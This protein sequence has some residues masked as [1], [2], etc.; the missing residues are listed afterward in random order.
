MQERC[1]RA[2]LSRSFALALSALLAL[3]TGARP[4]AAGDAATA[5]PL[6]RELSVFEA[7]ADPDAPESPSPKPTGEL[8]LA[9]ALAAALQGSP[10]LATSAYE[11]RRRE[12]LALQA[13]L[14]PNPVFSLQAEDFAGDSQDKSLGYQQTTLSLAQLVELGG[15]RMARRRLADRDRDLATWDFEAQRVAVLADTTKSFLVVL[16]LQERRTLFQD[17][18]RVAGEMLRSVASTVRAG[19][20]SPVEEDRAHVNLDRVRLEVAQIENDLEV[21]RT[22]LSSSWGQWQASFTR[23]AGDL[24]ALPPNPDGEELAA[25]APESPEIARWQAEIA[26]REAA[27]GVERA[28]RIPSIEL[29]IGARQHPLGDAQGVVAGVSIPVPVFDRNQG[30][31]LAARHQLAQVR[32][33]QRHA[34]T[35]VRSAL[36]ATHQKL[37]VASR[38]VTTLRDQIIPLADRVFEKTREGYAT[39][40]FR[41][42]EVLDAQ[43]T[44]FT[45]RRELIDA[46]L[47]AHIAA[48]DL[49]RLTGTP[50][51]LVTERK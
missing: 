37:I 15:K 21:A 39:G 23:V 28:A 22:G 9:D 29:S 36:V 2:R 27:L 3:A 47:A 10:A 50:L 7:D 44:L 35:S 14:R 5:R 48:T 26:Q 33:D 51:A 32:A 12:A 8:A 16:A 4:A 24:R 1:T 49:E 43:R 25:A 13:G 45:A 19:A 40:L 18:E 6:G 42:V 20:V 17:L 38:T 46:L 41:Y 11:I 31:L 34:E 30:S